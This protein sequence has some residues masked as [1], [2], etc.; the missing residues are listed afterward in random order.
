MHFEGGAQDRRVGAEPRR[1]EGAM[2][3][4]VP[5]DADTHRGQ[6]RGNAR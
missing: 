6:A 4:V 1:G 3:A 5:D 2:D